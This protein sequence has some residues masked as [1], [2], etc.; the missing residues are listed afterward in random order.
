MQINCCKKIRFGFI[1]RSFMG[2]FAAKNLKHR[3][4]LIMLKNIVCE[5]NKL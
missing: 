1:S 5:G 3:E 2:A 4:A